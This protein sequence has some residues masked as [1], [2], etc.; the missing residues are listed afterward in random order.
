[1]K[2][3]L[4]IHPLTAAR[5]DDLTVLFGKSGAM[6]GCWCMYWRLTSRDFNATSGQAHREALRVMVEGG[7]VPGLLAYVD[8]QPAGWVSIAPRESHARLVASRSLRPVDEQ[9]VWSIVCFFIGRE[10]RRQ[11]LAADLVRA[12]VAYVREQGAPAVEAYPPDTA[13]SK[14]PESSAYMGTL[15]MFLD[16]GFHVVR[17]IEGKGNARPRCIVRQDLPAR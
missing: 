8:G 13:H 15:D 14:I 9:P 3:E 12:A 4:Q 1:M 17:R 6:M 16:A 10:Y 2:D 5:W 11:G 7:N